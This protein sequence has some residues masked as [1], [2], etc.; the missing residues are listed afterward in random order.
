MFNFY[1]RIFML[2]KTLTISDKGQIVIPKEFVKHLESKLI[3]LEVSENQEVKII[4]IKDVAG[5]LTEFAK[6]Q[7]SDD[8]QDLRDQAWDRTVSEKFNKE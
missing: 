1:L 4:P 2:A 5:S 6:K 7:I 8:F 3:K